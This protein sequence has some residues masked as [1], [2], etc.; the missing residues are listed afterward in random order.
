M[1]VLTLIEIVVAVSVF[2]NSVLAKMFLLDAEMAI[3]LF[4]LGYSTKPVVPSHDQ[5]PVRRYHGTRIF[6]LW[7]AVYL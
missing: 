4:V 3:A 7:L 2:A 1:S 5:C 6:S